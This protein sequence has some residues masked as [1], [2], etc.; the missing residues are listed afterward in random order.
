MNLRFEFASYFRK[1][2]GTGQFT[3]NLEGQAADLD[4]AITA[5]FV[6]HPDLFEVLKKKG[7]LRDGK[8]VAMFVVEGNLLQQESV[9]QDG[10][11]I[12]VMA[13]ICGG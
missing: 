8:L 2:A 11:I 1:I 10:A 5:L 6:T 4:E 7:F 3:V 13:P 9:L 12:K